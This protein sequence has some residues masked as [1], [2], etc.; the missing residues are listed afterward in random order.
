MHIRL[1]LVRAGKYYSHGKLSFTWRAAV[2]VNS[3]HI[4]LALNRQRQYSLGKPLLHSRQKVISYVNN[5]FQ[6]E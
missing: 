3:I 5:I 4:R 1:A 6:R 2:L